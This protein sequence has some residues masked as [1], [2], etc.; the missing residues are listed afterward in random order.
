MDNPTRLKQGMVDLLRI[1]NEDGDGGT[2]SLKDP[3]VQIGID[4]WRN[5]ASEP[6]I[7]ELVDRIEMLGNHN[8]LRSDTPHVSRSHVRRM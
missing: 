4:K 2:I 8:D 3:L 5:T 7:L 6:Q 1:L